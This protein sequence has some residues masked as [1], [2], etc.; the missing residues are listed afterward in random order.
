MSAERKERVD[1]F[2]FL[3]DK[4]R[5]VAGEMLARKAISERHHVPVG[6]IQFEKNK[7][8]K[9]F[10]MD[11][12][13]EFNISHSGNIV[14]CAVSDTPVGIDIE[15]IRSVDLNIVKHICTKREV[16]YLFRQV[17]SEK[18]FIKSSNQSL[19]VR[20]FQIWTTKEAYFKCIGTGITNLKKADYFSI[21]EQSQILQFIQI[22]HM[23]SILSKK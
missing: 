4:K 10:A 8:G 3:D 7:H 2:R 18:D 12:P 21:C 11:F 1:H 5:T 16:E 19:L 23:I 15:E 6:D 14:V 20:L 22:N 17:P 9:P 13:V